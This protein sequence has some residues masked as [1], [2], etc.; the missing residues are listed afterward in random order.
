MFPSNES[1]LTSVC[2]I[3]MKQA[4]IALNEERYADALQLLAKADQACLPQQCIAYTRALCYVGSKDMPAAL[5]ELERAIQ[6]D[7]RYM[8]ALILK[9]KLLWETGQTLAGNNEMWKA[10]AVDHRHPD[11]DEFLRRMKGS[12]DEYYMLAT[13]DIFLGDVKRAFQHLQVALEFDHNSTKVL[14]LK[15]GLYRR[16]KQFEDALRE[17]ELATKRMHEEN[18]Q[19]E[20]NRQISLT[21]ND[22]ALHLFKDRLYEDAI[23]LLNEAIAFDKK[24]VDFYISRADCFRE[25]KKYQQALADYHFCL[26]LQPS[27]AEVENRLAYI[28]NALGVDLYNEGRYEQAQVEFTRAIH[29]RP[30][31]A[32]FFVNRARA[33]YH[34]ADMDQAFRD[35]KNAVAIDPY[36]AE[37]QTWLEQFLPTKPSAA[38][39]PG[40]GMLDRTQHL[41]IKSPNATRK[42][43][44]GVTVARSPR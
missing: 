34:S 38:L 44:K 16:Q 40:S 19:E 13:R 2:V 26:E 25:L 30:Q 37:A 8:D 10:H 4:L 43:P 23:V 41:H 15:A 28:H 11:V 1:F 32:E 3:A 31:N 14:L 39:P 27:H 21:Y 35:Y 5:Y 22:M 17:L 9:A 12:S 33:A 36:H 18:L 29:Y 7:D 6:V 20:V 42:P 24:E